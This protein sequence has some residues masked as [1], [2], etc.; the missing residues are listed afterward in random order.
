[1]TNELIS[2]FDRESNSLMHGVKVKDLATLRQRTQKLFTELMK[3]PE[4]NPEA[5]KHLVR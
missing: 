1:M 5:A 3:D 2:L 4:F